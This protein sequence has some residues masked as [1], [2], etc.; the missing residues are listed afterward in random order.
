MKK[1]R[2]K[3]KR[4]YHYNHNLKIYKSFWNN[5]EMKK[6]KMIQKDLINKNKCLNYKIKTIP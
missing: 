2:K 5:S 3:L 6:W 1:N 4:T